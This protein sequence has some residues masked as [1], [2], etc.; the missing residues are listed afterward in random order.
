MAQTKQV[1][2]S[3]FVGLVRE[4]SGTRV[5]L[6]YAAVQSVLFKDDSQL[7]SLCFHKVLVAL[8]IATRTSTYTH[9]YTEY[10]Y[11]LRT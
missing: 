1:F 3:Y 5:E 11:I 8:V 9:V 4:R 2:T 7:L 6:V 10:M